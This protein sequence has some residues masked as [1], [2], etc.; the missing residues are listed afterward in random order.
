MQILAKFEPIEKMEIEAFIS[1]H[2]VPCIPP[3]LG[4]LIHL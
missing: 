4:A 1:F 3:F 2:F